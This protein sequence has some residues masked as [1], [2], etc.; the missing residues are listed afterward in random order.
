MIKVATILTGWLYAQQLS[1]IQM[2]TCQCLLARLKLKSWSAI[3]SCKEIGVMLEFSLFF[4]FSCVFMVKL[5][6]VTSI[7]ESFL[8]D[9]NN[10]NLDFELLL[11]SGEKVLLLWCK[12]F[13]FKYIF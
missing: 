5:L 7:L 8:F 11:E 10:V 13:V 4:F 6:E 12:S 3:N 9:N 2:M 1:Q